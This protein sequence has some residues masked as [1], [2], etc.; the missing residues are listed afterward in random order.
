MQKPRSAEV[1][2]RKKLAGIWRGQPK[3]E[4]IYPLSPELNDYWAQFERLILKERIL[5][6]KWEVANLRQEQRLKLVILKSL[7]KRN[8]CCLCMNLWQLVIWEWRRPC[9]VSS[10]GTTGVE[11]AVMQR[12]ENV[13]SARLEGS[14]RK[15]F[16]PHYK[17]TM[18][19]LAPL[20]RLAINIYWGLCR[21]QTKEIGTFW[22]LWIIFRNGWR[23]LPCLDNLQ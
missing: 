13:L 16:K 15:G 5:Y 9:S 4:Q 12:R 11:A 7:L 19:W 22:W 23:P 10:S 18:W 20:E 14:R 21:K 8:C 6:C 17:F 2:I 3:W 1:C